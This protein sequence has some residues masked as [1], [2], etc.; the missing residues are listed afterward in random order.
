MFKK[1]IPLNEVQSY[2]E[3]IVTNGLEKDLNETDYFKEVLCDNCHGTGI[4]VA[5]NPYGLSEER[6]AVRFPYRQQAFTFC[7]ECFNGIRKRCKV[8]G[9]L[10]PRGML[11]HNCQKIKE[12][13]KKKKE[14]EEKKRIDSLP[15]TEIKETGEINYYSEYFPYNEGYF[16]DFEEFFE[17]IDDEGIEERPEYC[18]GVT[19]IPFKIDAESV[20]ENACEDSYED[21]YDHV[22]NIRSL[23]KV[24]DEWIEKNGPG[25][26][27]VYNKNVKVRIPWE[28][29]ER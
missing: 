8:C 17:A 6:S 16:Y 25:S 18:F 19:E 14:E 3:T 5:N 9:E 22:G 4:V 26:S 23:Q 15:W 1:I 12:E 11:I 28:K 27:Y 24:I 7:P 2:I 10:I 20:V 13:E 21:A 29:Y